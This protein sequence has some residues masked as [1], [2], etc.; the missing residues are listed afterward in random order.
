MALKS[1]LGSLLM[2][3]DIITKR[4]LND[5]I[6]KQSNGD[7]RKLGEI[8]VAAGYVTVEDLT[9]VMLGEAQEA[10]SER[11]K[12]K[13]DRLLQKQILQKK[14]VPKPVVPNAIPITAKP[15]VSDDE[16]LKKKFTLSIQ[17]MVAA[18]TGLVSLI[19][20]W[21]ALQAD[22]QANVFKID[23]LGKEID[24]LRDGENN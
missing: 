21:Y 23:T 11:E 3:A 5:A 15:S 17:T 12:S 24:R 16:I 20:M 14:I 22:I 13:R 9:E 6:A 18:I 2:D 19:G 8:L 7:D 10:Q 4:Q 1:K